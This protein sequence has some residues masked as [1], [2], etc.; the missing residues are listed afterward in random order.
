MFIRWVIHIDAPKKLTD[1]SQESGRAGRDGAKASSIIL[2]RSG[3]KPQLDA[4]LAP[5]QEAMQLYLAQK[6]CSRGILSQFLDA[7]RDWR[8]CM[9]GEECCQVC[10]QPHKTQRPRGVHFRLASESEV[11]YTGPAE[12]LR[13]DYVRDRVIDLYEKD[14]EIMVGS[15]LY[16]R[17]GGRKFDHEVGMCRRRFHW[18]N[19]KT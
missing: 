13:Q 18:I 6:Y 17:V 19:A 2:L 15:C 11:Q 1:F 16:C 5:D 3:W 4:D 9:E 12:V 10:G 14:L 8:W 7:E